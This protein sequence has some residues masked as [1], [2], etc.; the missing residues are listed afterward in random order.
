MARSVSAKSSLV[1]F[2]TSDIQA[3]VGPHLDA[4]LVR[5][6][7]ELIGSEETD[8]LNGNGRPNTSR[9]GA[10]LLE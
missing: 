1:V 4:P 6:L 2:E 7:Q 10:A 5:S 3:P 8:L 9:L